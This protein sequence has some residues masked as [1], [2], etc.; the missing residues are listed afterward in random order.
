MRVA[1]A[2]TRRIRS[3][4][5]FH[6]G[7]A[8]GLLVQRATVLERTVPDDLAPL[9]SCA[10]VLAG[11]AT[12]AGLPAAEEL[13]RTVTRA[14]GRKQRRRSRCRRRDSGSRPT[15]RSWHEGV[16]RTADRLGLVMAGDVGAAALALVGAE[17]RTAGASTADAAT[18]PA[19]LDLLR[20][21]LGEPYPRAAEGGGG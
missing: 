18:N 16:L 15:T 6:V 5:R 21:A 4:F 19:A 9:F 14:L 1:R 20:F 8:L 2:P 13:L 3:A 7:R 11:V 12:P 10:A 17:G